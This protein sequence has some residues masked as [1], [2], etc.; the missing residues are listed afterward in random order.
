MKEEVFQAGLSH[1][2]ELDSF[3]DIWENEKTAMNLKIETL[4][5][6]K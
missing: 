3:R 5:K 6:A 4:K 1:Q 2:K